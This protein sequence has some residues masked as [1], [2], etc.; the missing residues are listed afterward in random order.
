MNNDIDFQ[1][2]GWLGAQI[3]SL[4]TKEDLGLHLIHRRGL[5]SIWRAKVF[6]H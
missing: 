2:V 4:A 6:S 3:K 5:M 1:E